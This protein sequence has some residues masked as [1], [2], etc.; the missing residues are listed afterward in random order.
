MARRRKVE[1][2]PL[3]DDVA[4]EE[5]SGEI[6]ALERETHDPKLERRRREV[7]RLESKLWRQVVE[8]ARTVKRLRTARRSL[9]AMQRARVVGT[10]GAR[11]G[12]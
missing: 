8:L 2:S 5:L 3:L 6:D 11:H 9:S 10:K 4:E 1:P 12:R 7:E